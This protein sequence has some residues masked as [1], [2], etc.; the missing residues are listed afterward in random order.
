ME[1][2]VAFVMA[3]HDDHKGHGT[4]PSMATVADEAGLQNRETASRIVTRLVDYKVIRAPHPSRG[5]RPTVYFFNYE[6]ANCDSPV[7][8][9]EPRTVTPR[10]QLRVPNC[11]SD[12]VEN[13]PTVTLEGS[14]RDS[15]VTGRGLKDDDRR[16]KSSSSREA[17]GDSKLCSPNDDRL[18][19]YKKIVLAKCKDDSDGTLSTALD[20][21]IERARRSGVN[22]SS[23]KY[24]ETAL[25]RFN[26]QEGQDREDW[27]AASRGRARDR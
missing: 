20:I 22:V 5:R 3:D 19:D 1:K 12:L 9:A 8:V 2:V 6:L 23:P 18:D 15:P 26:F 13:T 25:E 27:M 10:S 7:T 17:I 4:Y 14:N 16:G 11:D 21:I 24:L